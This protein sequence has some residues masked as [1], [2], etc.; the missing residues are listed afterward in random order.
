M[1]KTNHQNEI[2]VYNVVPIFRGERIIK[3]ITNISIT[4]LQNIYKR[5][6][7]DENT[8]RGLKPVKNKKR[9]VITQSPIMN[10]KNIVEMKEKIT[11]KDFFD[12]GTLVWN[13]RINEIKNRKNF[14]EYIPEENKVIIKGNLITLPDSA[15]RH[16][17]LYELKDSI[18]IDKNTF[19]LPLEICFYTMYEEQTLFSEINGCGQKATKTR[20]LYLSNNMKAYL[21]KEIIMNSSLYGKVD[22]K[23]SMV[24]RSNYLV[25]FATLYDSLFHDRRG[26]YKVMLEEEKKEKKEWLVKFYNELIDV[27]E[28]LKVETL[29]EKTLVR[30]NLISSSSPMF[31]AYAHIAKALENDR[32]WRRKLHRLN[33]KKFKYG[34]WE[35]DILSIDNPAWHGTIC[36]M[37]KESQ[38]KLITS[39][40]SK[41]LLINIILKYLNLS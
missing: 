22:I 39:N 27:R 31:F 2:E 36:A 11:T 7:Y 40:R 5:L 25:T 35:G 38:W 12:G 30:Q 17:A 3:F 41:D 15:Q 20:S 28:E 32:N 1:I 10:K 18:N 13:V 9:E 29:E 24:Y 34:L 8:Q 16:K 4:E 23:S 21:L 19:N 26:A 14:Y 6:V 33:N 37:N